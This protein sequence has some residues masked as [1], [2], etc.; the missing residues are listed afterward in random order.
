MADF[1]WYRSFVAIYRAGSV[2]AAAASRHLTQPAL[3]QHLAALEAEVGEPLFH[4]RPR[5]MVPTERGIAL[6][7]QVAPAIDRLERATSELRG[8][9]REAAIRL[10]SPLEYFKERVV[11]T[12]TGEGGRLVV[13]FGPTAALLDALE[14]HLL[15][16]VIATQHLAR[17]GLLFIHLETEF[18]WLVGGPESTL[19]ADPSDLTAVRA[20][21]EG[22]PWISYGEDLPIIRRFWM[23]SFGERPG[24]T[25][26]MVV[27]DLHGIMGLVERGVGLSVLPS[28]LV[29][30]RVEARRLTRIWSP[31]RPVQNEIW[32]AYRAA[33]RN[34]AV[35]SRFVQALLP[36]SGRGAPQEGG[37]SAGE[38]RA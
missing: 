17:R 35:I 33:D 23:E 28:Y 25:P 11:P 26:R 14:A 2:S 7:N 31:S 5:K 4:R 10:G 37:A 27:P 24:I 16:V 6:Y 21:L 12:W 32:L 13:R 3:S 20:E 30:K 19:S 9:T 38:G 8:R 36:Q 18:F 15:D 22:R 1:E 29:E 34:D